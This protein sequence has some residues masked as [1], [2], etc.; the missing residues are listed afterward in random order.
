V[1]PSRPKLAALEAPSTTLV[2]S[3]AS[4]SDHNSHN[5]STAASTTATEVRAVRGPR[6]VPAGTTHDSTPRRSRGVPSQNP[7]ETVGFSGGRSKRRIA[8]MSSLPLQF[9]LLTVAGWSA[10]DQRRVT[11]YLLAEN[12]ALVG[13]FERDSSAGRIV[14]AYVCRTPSRAVA[15]AVEHT[16]GSANTAGS[17]CRCRCSCQRNLPSRRRLAGNNRRPL[18]D[19]GSRSCSVRGWLVAGRPSRRAT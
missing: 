1:V 19:N 12:A 16:A 6:R 17:M 8:V 9:L 18:R 2:T 14:R 7:G 11:E 5:P 15:S 10:G 3:I 13:A 4:R